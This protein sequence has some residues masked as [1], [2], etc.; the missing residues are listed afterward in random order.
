ME[1]ESEEKAIAAANVPQ[2]LEATWR[3]NNLQQLTEPH[4]NCT[5]SPGLHY[6]FA[7]IGRGKVSDPDQAQ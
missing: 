7:N 6:S 2:A 5:K 1:D 4:Y 3:K